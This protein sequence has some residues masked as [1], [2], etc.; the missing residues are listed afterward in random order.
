MGLKK[1]KNCHFLMVI[2]KSECGFF[3]IPVSLPLFRT[4]NNRL[5]CS[6]A[7]KNKRIFNNSDNIFNNLAP[8]ALDFLGRPKTHILNVKVNS[9]GVKYSVLMFYY[10]SFPD[11]KY[12]YAYRIIFV[13]T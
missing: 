13:G 8:W 5:V 9:L 11:F 6:L 12:G 1:Y 4:M 2:E 10:I 7:N 3:Q